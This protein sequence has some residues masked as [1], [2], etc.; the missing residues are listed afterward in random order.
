MIHTEVEAVTQRLI[1]HSVISAIDVV[2]DR[3]MAIAASLPT[4]QVLILTSTAFHF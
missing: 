4:E 3:L 1:F 2:N